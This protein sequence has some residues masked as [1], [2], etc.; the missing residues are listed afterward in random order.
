MTNKVLINQYID[1][2]CTTAFG[3]DMRDYFKKSILFRIEI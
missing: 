1:R 3:D 2:V